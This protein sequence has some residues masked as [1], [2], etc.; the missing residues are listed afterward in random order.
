MQG[1]S[2]LKCGRE[3]KWK[4]IFSYASYPLHKA[5]GQKAEYKTVSVF[6]MYCTELFNIMKHVAVHEKEKTDE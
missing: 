3:Y 4:K 1:L 6:S 5:D 2:W